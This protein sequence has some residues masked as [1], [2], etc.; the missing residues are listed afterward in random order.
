MWLFIKEYMKDMNGTQAAIRAGYSEKGAKVQACNLLKRPD[1]QEELR[2]L[3]DKL[4]A[5][6]SIDENYIIRE[7]NSNHMRG[8]E[9]DKISESN[10][11]LELMGKSLAMFTDRLKVDSGDLAAAI[12]EARIRAARN[13]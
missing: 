6:M 3:F 12:E 10:K 11:A 2:K 5:E 7:L 8:K 9:L 4:N 1:V 13:G